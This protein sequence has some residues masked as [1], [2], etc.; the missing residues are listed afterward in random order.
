MV[1]E[2][3]PSVV[4]LAFLLPLRLAMGLEGVVP[5]AGRAGWGCTTGLAQRHGP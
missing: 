3:L 1:E 5:Q 2:R 4:F